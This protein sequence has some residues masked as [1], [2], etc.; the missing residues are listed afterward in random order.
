MQMISKH[1]NSLLPGFVLFWVVCFPAQAATEVIVRDVTAQGSSRELAIINT[2]VEGIQQVHGITIDV[3]KRLLSEFKEVFNQNSGKETHTYDVTN[4]QRQ[5]LLKRSRGYVDTYEVLSAEKSEDEAVWEVTL[6]VEIPIYVSGGQD[7]SKM[8]TLVVAPFRVQSDFFNVGVEQLSADEVSWKLNHKIISELTQARKFRLLDREYLEEI[9]TEDALLRSGKVP[10]EETFRLGQRL[11]A[12]FVIAGIITDYWIDQ[13]KG[14]TLGVITTRLDAKLVFEFRVLEVAPQE[15]RWS[16]SVELDLDDA[17]LRDLSHSEDPMQVHAAI[18]ENAGATM[19]TNVLEVIFPIKVLNISDNEIALNQGGIR[20]K[21]GE[22]FDIFTPGEKVVDPDTGR[23][24]R[25]DGT[26]VG[27]LQV[28]R[29]LPKYSVGRMID[30]DIEMVEELAI[31]RRQAVDN[32][33]IKTLPDSG[34]VNW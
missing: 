16:G 34:T 6:R 2:L 25:L 19:A 21:K 33:L 8:R 4:S 14:N 11:G 17:R 10:I 5:D 23:K 24:I 18:L 1:L 20:V 28:I 30:G 32:D 15:I 27:T 29:V 22:L 9:K 31:C 12:D 7:R 3:Q 13:T 26:R